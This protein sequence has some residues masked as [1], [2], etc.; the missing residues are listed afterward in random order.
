MLADYTVLGMQSE[1]DRRRIEEMGGDPSKVTVLGNLKYDVTG[2]GRPLDSALAR[3]LG[4]WTPLW[5]AASTMAGEEEII[6]NAFQELRARLPELKLVLAPRHPERFDAVELLVRNRKL[7]CL[8]R[9][10]LQAGGPGDVLL[11]DSIG[12][13]SAVFEYASVVF[14]G[15]TLAPAGGH[16]VLEPARHHKPI[17]FGPHMENFR[18]IAREFPGA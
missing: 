17:V 12:E 7:S 8:R 13:L 9:T 18:D 2:P 5:V 3:V 4:Q 16:N 11:L 1:M 14:M 15:G 10:M 6:L